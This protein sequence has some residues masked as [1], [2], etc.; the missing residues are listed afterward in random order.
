MSWNPRSQ[1]TTKA[2]RIL[3]LRSGHFSKLG[4]DS[5][6]SKRRNLAK[7]SLIKEDNDPNILSVV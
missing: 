5:L 4:H 3:L 2:P 6:L 7:I 1:I